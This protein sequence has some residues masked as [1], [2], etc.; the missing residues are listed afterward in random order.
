[1]PLVPVGFGYHIQS[2]DVILVSPYPVNWLRDYLRELKA[3]GGRVYDLSLGRGVASIAILRDGSACRLHYRAEL[4]ADRFNFPQDQ[5]R[6]RVT[7]RWR[8]RG[9]DSGMAKRTAERR[10][11]E[12]EALEA[13]N[14]SL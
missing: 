6:Q 5:P 10:Q 12:N 1:M 13:S 11:A 14:I 9:A 3:S 8:A 7:G 2:E 4:I